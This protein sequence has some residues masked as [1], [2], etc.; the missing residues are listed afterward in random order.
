MVFSF[1][2]SPVGK[3]VLVC[4]ESHIHALIYKANWASMKRYF[5]LAKPGENSL[6]AKAAKQLAEYFSGKRKDFSLPLCWSGTSFQENAWQVLCDIPYGKTISYELQAQKMKNPK[7][8][9]AVGTANG[10]NPI[11]IFVPCHRVRGKNGSL[12]GYAGGVENKKY[13]LEL[14]GA[15]PRSALG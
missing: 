14:E 1:L 2:D 5:P 9:R 4:D 13:L 6:S 10:R 12:A 15:I 3:L 8:V 7:A 11:S